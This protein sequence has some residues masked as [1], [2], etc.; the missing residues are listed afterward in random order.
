MGE[1]STMIP[2]VLGGPAFDAPEA[3]PAVEGEKILGKFTS[4]EELIKA[5]SELEKKLGAPAQAPETAPEDKTDE[6]PKEEAPKPDKDADKTKEY[7]APLEKTDEDRAYEK[8]TYGEAMASV[9]DKAGLHAK[10][11][12][13]YFKENGT[14][15]EEA[16]AGL[17]KEGYTRPMVDSYLR[18]VAA[19]K[20]APAV[21]AEPSEAEKEAQAIVARDAEKAIM[22]TV[23]GKDAY[24]QMCAWAKSNMSAEEQGTYNRIMESGSKD[25]VAWAVRGLAQR[26]GKSVG[27]DPKLISGGPATSGE[28]GFSNWTEVTKAMRSPEY[29]T[30]PAYRAK[31]ADRM[32]RSN[33]S[34]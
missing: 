15:P 7:T 22:D 14:F 28:A 30:D 17:E 25:A 10:S 32:S 12:D 29:E 18:G 20:A 3:T 27:N 33:L 6:T 13:E 34:K 1:T 5:Y 23:G 11:V 2:P 24:L 8:E 4:Q 21:T 31:V 9:F 16:Y 19:S 26:Y